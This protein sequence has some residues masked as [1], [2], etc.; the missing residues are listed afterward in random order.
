MP[1]RTVAT[2]SATDS[3]REIR[4]ALVLVLRKKVVQQIAEAPQSL[5]HFGLGVQVLD[6]AAVAAGQR[7]QSVDKKRITQMPHIEEQF[8]VPRRAEL[9]T[10]AEHLHAQRRSPAPGTEAFE[11]NFSQRMDRMVR[12]I[13]DFVG[14]RARALHGNAFGADRVQQTLAAIGR[15]RS[16]SFAES[17]RQNFVGRF[18]EYD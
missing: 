11:Q 6:D 7:A 1:H 18:K 14:Q 4:L 12:S 5:C 10:K 13:Y 17:P 3:D 15:M 16:P 9:M 8:H 2:A